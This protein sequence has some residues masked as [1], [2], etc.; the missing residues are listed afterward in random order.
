LKNFSI[1]WQLASKLGGWQ[2]FSWQIKIGS[3]Q[4]KIGSWQYSVVNLN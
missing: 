2:L 1:S 4:I 3:W